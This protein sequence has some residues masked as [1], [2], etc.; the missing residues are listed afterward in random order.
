M[1]AIS[2][3]SLCF[4]VSASKQ[5]IL[6]VVASKSEFPSLDDFL[7]GALNFLESDSEFCDNWNE[8]Y[9]D[10]NYLP[11]SD[12]DIMQ[13]RSTLSE[14]NQRVSI[15]FEPIIK[16]FYVVPPKWNDI[17]L[18]LETKNEYVLYLWGTSA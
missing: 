6:I 14:M 15:L 1:I 13:M 18:V 12:D 7:A 2:F 10:R 9:K 11:A 16:A 5:S 17:S 8:I 4:N 3:G